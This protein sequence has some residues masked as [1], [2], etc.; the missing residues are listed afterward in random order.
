MRFGFCASYEKADAFAHAG[1][2]FIEECVQTFLQGNLPDERW[3]GMDK[4]QISGLPIS[5]AGVRCEWERHQLEN[6]NK[7]LCA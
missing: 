4:L 6:L 2:D 3:K 7:R 1:W 5:A